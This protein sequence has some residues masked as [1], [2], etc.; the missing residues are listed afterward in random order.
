MNN[1][2]GIIP[3]PQNL[4][5]PEGKPILLGRPGEALCHVDTGGLPG[6]C[7]SGQAAELLRDRLK[8][9]LNAEPAGSL[10]IRLLLGEAPGGVK[11]PQQGYRLEVDADSVTVTGFGPAGL[12]YG[13]ISLIECLRFECGALTL[14]P[15]RILD[16]PEFATRGHFMECR[17]G[18]NLMTLDD[19]KRLVDHMA[20]LKMN[21][22]VVGVYGCWCV[23]YDG[24][25][26]EYLYVPLK[27][28]PD[29]ATRR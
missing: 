8:G 29:L 22:L 4:L 10:P 26:S 18:T 16:W 9:L 3:V 11:N 5:V 17:F 19:W 7:L 23:Q 13:V 14:P 25:V 21:Q 20:F 15:M 24:R 6:D 1:Q 28:C 27:T 2:S 12:Y